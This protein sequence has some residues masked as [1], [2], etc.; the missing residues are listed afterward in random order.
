MEYFREKGEIYLSKYSVGIQYQMKLF[1]KK[2]KLRKKMVLNFLFHRDHLLNGLRRSLIFLT[3]KWQD[4]L[5][6]LYEN[7]PNFILPNQENEVVSFVKAGLK[8]LSVSRKSFSWGIKVP[9]NKDHVIYVWLDAL[10][11]Y[12]SALNFRIQMIN[13]IKIF[14]LPMFI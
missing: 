14:G 6:Q 3:S 9:S 4:K 10:T 8:D 13:C 12:I 1:I 7:N 2:M 5:L 11:N